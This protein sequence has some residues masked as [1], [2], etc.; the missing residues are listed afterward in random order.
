MEAKALAK[1][2]EKSRLLVLESAKE[3]TALKVAKAEILAELAIKSA[4]KPWYRR[5]LF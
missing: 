2:A 3:I 1:E 5:S 4:P